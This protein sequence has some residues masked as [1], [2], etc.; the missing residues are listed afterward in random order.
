MLVYYDLQSRGWFLK[1]NGMLVYIPD[2][3]L[4][5]DAKLDKRVV[6]MH[7]DH[8]PGREDDLALQSALGRL[9]PF[10]AKMI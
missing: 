6:V 4:V 7:A 9:V 2:P 1:P 8:L 3:E 5:W 10:K